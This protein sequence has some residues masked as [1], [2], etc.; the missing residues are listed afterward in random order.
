MNKKIIPNDMEV[1]SINAEYQLWAEAKFV[2]RSIY[3]S[4]DYVGNHFVV[5]NTSKAMMRVAEQEF[6]KP[7][8]HAIAV[9]QH[10]LPPL[11]STNVFI[12]RERGENE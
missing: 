6:Y 3:L 10:E 5:T 2:L 7:G 9:V 12:V 4:R 8:V 11:A 1:K